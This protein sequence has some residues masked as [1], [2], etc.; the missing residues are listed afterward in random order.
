MLRQDTNPSRQIRLPA[1]SNAHTKLYLPAFSTKTQSSN[2]SLVTHI[3]PPPIAPQKV[4]RG[5]PTDNQH[6]NHWTPLVRRNRLAHLFTPLEIPCL[7]IFRTSWPNSQKQNFHFRLMQTLVNNLN[8][9][10][11]KKAKKPDVTLL[12]TLQTQGGGHGKIRQGTGKSASVAKP[13][14]DRED[15]FYQ[16]IS[17]TPLA[18]VIPRYLGT[19][20]SDG[21][22]F[23]VLQDLTAG[24]RSPCIA[25][26]KLGTRS[27]EVNAPREKAR[28]QLAHIVNTTTASHAARCIDICTR[29]NGE[30]VRRWDRRDGRRMSAQEFRDALNYF[31]PGKRREEFISG[32][33][34]L[35]N[36]LTQ[37][38]A[39]L[40][41]L[42]L[43][44]A[45]VLV[46]Y[47][48]DDEARPMSVSIID[49]AHAYIDVVAEGGDAK[50]KS[51]D[52]NSVRG[53]ESLLGM[54]MS[55]NQVKK[56]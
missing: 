46:I 24:M 37:T 9:N 10:R 30:V 35:R 31:L 41:N 8:T 6:Y 1:L 55:G 22:D 40:P 29:K 53:L 43:Y 14:I 42:R 26:I 48:G 11:P 47:D 34:T 50:D 39:I 51:F 15:R 21:K 38:L 2:I 32:I 28:R 20:S 16:Q 27:F 52:D 33:K 17:G 5:T 19:L 23:L 3:Y 56:Q 13:L 7:T 44:S 54:T 49:F 45:S 18:S 12:G 4:I 25:D 36:K